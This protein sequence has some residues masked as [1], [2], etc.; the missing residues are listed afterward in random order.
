MRTSPTPARFRLDCSRKGT[1]LKGIWRSFGYDEINWTYSP[2]GKQI[3]KE[4]GSLSAEPYYTRCHNTFTSGNSLSIPT[5]GS[6]NVCTGVT[7]AQLSL[8]FSVLDQVLDTVSQHGCR[9]IVELGFMP[10][11]LAAGGAPKPSYDYRGPECWRYPPAN[12]HRWRELVRATVEHCVQR[13]GADEVSTWYWEVWNEPDNPGFFKGNIKDYCKMYDFAVAG[14]LEAF[15][16]IRIGGPGLAIDTKFLRKFLRHCLDGK[17][18]ATGEK[19]TRLDFISCHAKGTEWPLKGRPFVMP[20]LGKI[21]QHIRRYANVLA[22][23]PEFK[24]V[25]ILLD[26]CDMAV[27]TN[28]GVYDFPELVINNNEYYPIFIVRMAKYL[29]DFI[30]A[31]DLPVQFFTTWAYYF[32]GKRFFEGNRALFTNENIRKP[33]LNAFALLERLGDEHLTMT[34][35]G[36]DVRPNDY[37]HFPAID[38]FAT[39]SGDR[40][41]IVLWNFQ[42]K[43]PARENERVHVEVVGAAFPKP[44]KVRQWCIDKNHS[45]SHTAWQMLGAPQDPTPEQIAQIKSRS[46]L[47][48]TEFAGELKF[49]N[50]SV[51]F[52]LEL[53]AHSVILLEIS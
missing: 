43:Y 20:S 3:Y 52:D 21:F 50:D 14:A 25:P 46:E 4:I 45:N 8:D 1:P 35:L 33:V 16:G 24:E 40:L 47:Q 7:N 49:E 2:R 53:P 29:W 15:S 12:Y 6:T 5:R 9:P 51:V 42:E 13:Y 36:E 11:S 41:S 27:A 44:P 18:R 28:F 34:R 10:D 17:N 48:N 37:Q 26:E 32:E 22:G 39:G 31:R 19:G 23:F 30:A 38:G